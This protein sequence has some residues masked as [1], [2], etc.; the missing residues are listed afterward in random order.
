MLNGIIKFL[1][2]NNLPALANL[3]SLANLPALHAAAAP[4]I[5]GVLVG[6]LMGM[7]PTFAAAAASIG[8]LGYKLLGLGA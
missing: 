6:V 5:G 1:N 4:I 3:P 8:W 2:L 7:T